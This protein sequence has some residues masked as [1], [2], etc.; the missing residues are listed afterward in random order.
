MLT[1][2]HRGGPQNACGTGPPAQKPEK[3]SLT[4]G[5]DA[6]KIARNEG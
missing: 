1:F 6:Q 2:Q 4:F 5:P 3:A